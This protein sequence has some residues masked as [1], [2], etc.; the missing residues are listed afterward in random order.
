MTT[1]Q[2][3]AQ[4]DHAALAEELSAAQFAVNNALAEVEELCAERSL[5][6]LEALNRGWTHARIASITGLSRSRIAQIKATNTQ[7]E[8]H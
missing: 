5:V 7:E 6:V 4:R 3:D 2:S 8:K 1:D